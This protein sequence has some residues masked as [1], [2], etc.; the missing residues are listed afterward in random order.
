MQ[1]LDKLREGELTKW[2]AEKWVSAFTGIAVMSNRKS[3]PHVDRLASAPWYDMLLTVGT[4]RRAE[5]RLPDIGLTFGYD[6]G[7]VVALCGNTLTH[8]VGD[9]GKGDRICYALFMRKEVLSRFGCQWVGWSTQDSCVER[10][11]WH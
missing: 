6:P 4:Y 8:E 2:A 7:T 9:W 5:L 10:E 11:P 1:A 3:K